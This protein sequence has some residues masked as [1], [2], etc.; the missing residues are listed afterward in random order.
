MI[1]I[2]SFLFLCAMVTTFSFAFVSCSDDDDPTGGDAVTGCT[3]PAALNYNANATESDGNC[4]FATENYLGTYN[5]RISCGGTLAAVIPDTSVVFRITP[6]LDAAVK[7][8]VNIKV[9]GVEALPFDISAGVNGMDLVL[10]QQVFNLPF[11]GIGNLDLDIEGTASID[12]NELSSEF[13]IDVFVAGTMDV[14]LADQ[15]C[16]ISGTKQ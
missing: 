1:S 7:D 9:D 14:F 12:G 3:N 15:P 4:E 8:S 16:S 11:E 10:K 13:L 5:G 2:R 6:H